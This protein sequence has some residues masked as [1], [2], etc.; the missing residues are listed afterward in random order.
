MER[1][2]EPGMTPGERPLLAFV[3]SVMR[4]ELEWAREA[5]VAALSQNPTL[6]P[7]SFEFAPPSSQAAD[8]AYLTKVREADFCIWLVGAMTTDPVR[9]EVAEALSANTRIW[10]IL[11]PAESRDEATTQL[12]N[13]VREVAKTGNADNATE[14]RELLA[15]TFSDEIIRGLRGIP[16]MTRLAL[17]EQIGRRSRERMVSRWVAVGLDRAEAIGLADD[18]SVGAPS[19]GIQPGEWRRLSIVVGDVGAGKSVTAERSLQLALCEA[20]S[21]RVLLSRCSFTSVTRETGLSG[22]CACMRRGLA[23]FGSKVHMQLSMEPTRYPQRLLLA[24]S[25][26]LVKWRTHFHR[27]GS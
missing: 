24:S 26:R 15:L 20:A 9:N 23:T 18:E 2:A 8:T 6:V 12:L 13:D 21:G 16:G 10:A 17:L 1:E 5:T 27:P 22:A 7:W 14:L 25:R 11:L 19:P 3:S 4:P